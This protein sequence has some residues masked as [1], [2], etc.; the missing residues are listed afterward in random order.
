MD[1]HYKEFPKGQNICRFTLS[2]NTSTQGQ[3]HKSKIKHNSVYSAGKL[4][5]N[6][7]VKTGDKMSGSYR[8]FSQQAAYYSCA[9][10]GVELAG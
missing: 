3:L 5:D 10:A 9:V 4:A 1:L 2:L 8:T 7:D 6:F